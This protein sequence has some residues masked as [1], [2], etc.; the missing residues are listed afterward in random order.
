M[1]DNLKTKPRALYVRV[2]DHLAEAIDRMT[3]RFGISGSDVAR[4]A[5]TEKFER[6]AKRVPA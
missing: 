6:E 5:L 1:S 2:D 3:A 4:I